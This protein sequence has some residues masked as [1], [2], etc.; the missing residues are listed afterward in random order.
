MAVD[1]PIYPLF[2]ET[3]VDCC[4]GHQ[5]LTQSVESGRIQGVRTTEILLRGFRSPRGGRVGLLL[6][7][8]SYLANTVLDGVHGICHS[9]YL[10]CRWLCHLAQRAWFCPT[11]VMTGSNA[12][13]P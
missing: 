5:S 3:T 2:Y 1:L 7:P 12:A 10:R 9:T 13:H 8:L 6:E 4:L 11:C